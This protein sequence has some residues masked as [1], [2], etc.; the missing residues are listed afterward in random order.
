MLIFLCNGSSIN[1][2][3]YKNLLLWSCQYNIYIYI[4]YIP[5]AI[6]ISVNIFYIVGSGG[7][8]PN[9]H[10][11]YYPPQPYQNLYPPPNLTYYQQPY[12]NPYALQPNPS[13][14][15]FPAPQ[16]TPQLVVRVN[17]S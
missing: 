16:P 2:L 6:T 13:T 17:D 9:P 1:I 14:A 7:Y 15:N 4:L 10:H 3:A 8:P 11:Q 12:S 5:V